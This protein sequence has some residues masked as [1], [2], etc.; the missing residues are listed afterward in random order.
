MG[1]DGRNWT[2]GVRRQGIVAMLKTYV[3]PGGLLTGENPMWIIVFPHSFSFPFPH[4]GCI[5]VWKF[6]HSR[7]GSCSL[8]LSETIITVY[9]LKPTTENSFSVRNAA[10][11]TPL[12]VVD[13]GREI[14]VM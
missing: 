8:K 11:R 10:D 9:A 1:M 12:E 6:L 2:Y 5:V 4:Y 3:V 7:Y 14:E 13:I